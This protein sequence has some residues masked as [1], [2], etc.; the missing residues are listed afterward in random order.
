MYTDLASWWPVLSPPDEYADEAPVMAGLLDTGPRPVRTLLELGCGGG[1]LAS[2]LPAELPGVRQTLVDISEQMLAVSR[3]LN[4]VAEH[5][6]DDMRTMRLGRQFDAVLVHDAI[7]YLLTRDEIEALAATVAA[8]LAP[9]GAA[10][11]APDHAADTFRPGTDWGGSDAPD[12][13]SARYLEWTHDPNPADTW[14]Q[15]DYAFILRD[16]NGRVTYEGETHRFGLFAVSDWL[17]VVSGAGLD[18]AAVAEQTDD[19]RQPR[20]LVVAQKPME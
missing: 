5:L 18:T 17:E 8:H 13:R 10:V 19:D 4:P 9:G 2:H 15:A 12:G 11:L 7:D 20:T 3:R 6:L 1:H 14:A 16:A